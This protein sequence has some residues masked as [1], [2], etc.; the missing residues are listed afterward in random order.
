MLEQHTITK[1]D[2]RKY[3]I[4]EMIPGI[5]V[6]ST[7][8]ITLTLSFIQPVWAMYFIIAFDLYW[9]ARIMYMLFLMVLSYFKFKK[10]ERVNWKK[11]VQQLPDWHEY[12]H[13]IFIPTYKE[14][15]EVLH[16]TF[17]ALVRNDYPLDAFIVVL[18]G[19][20]KDRENFTRIADRLAHEFGAKFFRFIVTLHPAGIAGRNLLIRHTYPM[21]T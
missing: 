21:T 20:E 9:L 11:K 16:S 17:T 19:E 14:P 10:T 5:M 4:L 6:W 7:F 18:A 15:Y 1:A 13:L 8:V 3:R 2:Y 12:K